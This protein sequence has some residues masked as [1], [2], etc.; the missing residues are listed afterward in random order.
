MVNRTT[1]GISQGSP[2]HN[3]IKAHYT[4]CAHVDRRQA[5]VVPQQGCCLPQ[6]L[7]IM[8]FSSSLTC[9]VIGFLST[10]RVSRFISFRNKLFSR[11]KRVPI[12]VNFVTRVFYDP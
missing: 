12:S 4:R 2:Q 10:F 6:T 1:N 3:H 11:C 9:K 5:F 7:N 8:F